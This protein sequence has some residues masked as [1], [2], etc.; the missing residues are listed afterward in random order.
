ML[1]WT[2]NPTYNLGI[3]GAAFPARLDGLARQTRSFDQIAAVESATIDLNRAGDST[4]IGAVKVTANFF[5]TLGIQPLRQNL[6]PHEDG[7]KD[8][9]V[10]ISHALWQRELAATRTS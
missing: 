8:K 5:S 2:D 9:V 1:I 3:H 10:V 7:G 6:H 4:R